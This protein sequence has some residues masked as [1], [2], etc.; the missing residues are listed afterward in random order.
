MAARS[1]SPGAALLRSSRLFSIPAPIPAAGGDYSSA[2][3]HYSATATKPYPTLMTITTP[4]ASRANGDWG[5]KRP[6]PLKSTT[7]QT[8]PLM[9]VRQVDSMEH[10]TDYQTASDHSIT[11]KKFQELNLPVTVNREDSNYQVNRGILRDPKSVFEKD[12]DITAVGSMEEAVKTENSRWKF[13]G[14]WLAG[15]TDGEFDNWLKKSVRSKRPEFREYLRKVHAEQISKEQEKT[16]IAE[17]RK[18][19]AAVDPSDITESQLLDFIRAMR[20][21]RLELFRHVSRFLDLAPL[22]NATLVKQLATSRGPVDFTLDNPYSVTGPPVTHPSAGIS[23][24]R[25]SKYMQNHPLYGPQK[26]HAPVKARILKPK[27][28]SMGVHQ[29][30]VGIAGFVA[31][32][33]DEK[34]MDMNNYHSKKSQKLRDLELSGGGGSKVYF[35]VERASIDPTGKIQ[36]Q[37]APTSAHP[38]HELV[39]REL[40]GEGNPDVYANAKKELEIRVNP[41]FEVQ[42]RSQVVFGD[43]DAYG[44]ARKDKE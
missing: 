37:I 17:G 27:T 26:E 25:T 8:I 13:S 21:D 31:K 32:K 14:P 5:L 22:P 35:D 18:T 15:M 33:F 42:R 7:Q 3:E 12:S 6:L 23:Y 2:T 43:K 19:P 28:N 39:H 38:M 20:Q 29:T 41:R 44:F 40:I 9:R 36:I 1:V 34:M 24:L 4:S 16:A 30:V 11:L 10:I